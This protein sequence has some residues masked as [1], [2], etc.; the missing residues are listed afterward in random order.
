MG[1]D[2]FED[3]FRDEKDRARASGE[4]RLREAPEVPGASKVLAYTNSEPYDAEVLVLYTKDFR[5]QLT[6]SGTKGSKDAQAEVEPI[7]TQLMKTLTMKG[8]DPISPIR[9]ESGGDAE[10]AED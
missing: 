7:F 3:T 5:C 8:M 4:T 1:I 9:M 10:D 2:K 6:V